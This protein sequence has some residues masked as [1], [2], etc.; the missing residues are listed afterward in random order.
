MFSASNLWYCDNAITYS[1]AGTDLSRQLL[2]C[3][4]ENFLEVKCESITISK[5][6]NFQ[7]CSI[8]ETRTYAKDKKNTY[9][10]PGDCYTIYSLVDTLNS[11]LTSCIFQV[12]KDAILNDFEAKISVRHNPT[13]EF[14]DLVI[15]LPNSLAYTFGSISY[16]DALRYGL[17]N[18]TKITVVADK[19]DQN[20]SFNVSLLKTVDFIQIGSNFM[21]DTNKEIAYIQFTKDDL[22]KV[23]QDKLTIAAKNL[24]N[25]YIRLNSLGNLLFKISLVQ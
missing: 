14:K 5:L 9:T 10:I 13:L 4:G 25:N 1:F 6:H 3:I 2:D 19:I 11:I 17:D 15:S 16:S 21:L 24:D 18:H 22:M 8:I 7:Q 20:H 23:F 12:D